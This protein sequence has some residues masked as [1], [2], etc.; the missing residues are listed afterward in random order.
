MLLH[1]FKEDFFFFLCWKQCSSFAHVSLVIL[2]HIL[3][4]KIKI[5]RDSRPIIAGI[6][7]RAKDKS[8]KKKKI[9]NNTTTFYLRCHFI[10]VPRALMNT[11]IPR[12]L[13]TPSSLMREPSRLDIAGSGFSLQPMLFLPQRNEP[14]YSLIPFWHPWPDC[15]Q[16][17]PSTATTFNF[18]TLTPPF[19]LF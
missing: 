3:E 8:H 2:W 12:R 17:H 15:L 6:T 10:S 9:L 1:N 5:R 16:T 18:L 13:H 19:F 7:T 14:S 11:V 4:L